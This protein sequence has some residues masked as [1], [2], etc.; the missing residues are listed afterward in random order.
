MFRRSRRQGGRPRRTASARA[1]SLPADDQG[2]LA[3]TPLPTDFPFGASFFSGIARLSPH[4]RLTKHCAL[5]QWARIEKPG[6]YR[7]RATL[8]EEP[9][10]ATM[11]RVLAEG[12]FALT[13][14]PKDADRVAARCRQI[15]REVRRGINGIL[16]ASDPG[17]SHACLLALLSVRDDAAVKPLEALVRQWRDWP[18][19]CRAL[20]RIGS[21]LAM[22][23][24]RDLARCEGA[25]GKSARAALRKPVAPETRNPDGTDSL[26]IPDA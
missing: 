26:R 21:P 19:G 4:G 13:V 5:T 17:A 3:G 11:G 6:Q 14:L 9:G 7:V 12:E 10:T 20:R 18:E 16:A 22:K 2:Q 23:V 15:A 24:L 25:I 8:R 1:L